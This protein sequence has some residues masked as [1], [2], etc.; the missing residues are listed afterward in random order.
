MDD[1]ATSA[2][3]PAPAPPERPEP[4]RPDRAAPPALDALVRYAVHTVLALFGGVL[5]ATTSFLAGWPR[6]VAH[7]G[8]LGVLAAIAGALLLAALVYAASRAAGWATRSRLDAALVGLGWLL[9]V[10]GFAMVTTSTVFMG[11]WSDYVFLITGM[12]AVVIAPLQAA[13]EDV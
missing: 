9:V 10:L 2:P 8:A 4:A 12:A 13:A 11:S 3:R 7:Q 6:T 1:D 5:G